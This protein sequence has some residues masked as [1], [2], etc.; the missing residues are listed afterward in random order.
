MDN[1]VS[2]TPKGGLVTPNSN[3]NSEQSIDA[4]E[5]VCDALL[6]AMTADCQYHI[7]KDHEA[8]IEKHVEAFE[9]WARVK[10]CLSAFAPVALTHTTLVN[11]A[12]QL[13]AM[14]QNRLQGKKR[15]SLNMAVMDNAVAAFRTGATPN[16]RVAELIDRAGVYGLCQREDGTPRPD[17]SDL[18]IT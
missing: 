16:D 12:F 3:W 14:L 11:V 7:V 6:V 2:I 5:A 9:A 17:V 1:V 10:L 8:R 13:T 15:A 4:L 18:L